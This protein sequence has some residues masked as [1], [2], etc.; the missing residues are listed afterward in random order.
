MLVFDG[1][2]WDAILKVKFRYADLKDT[3]NNP[4]IN[5]TYRNPDNNNKVEGIVIIIVGNTYGGTSYNEN[6]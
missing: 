1:H 2:D 6:N 3:A 4:V 5:M